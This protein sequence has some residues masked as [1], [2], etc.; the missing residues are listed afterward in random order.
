[1]AITLHE[2]FFISSRLLPAIRVGGATVSIEYAA[3]PPRGGVRYRYHID[4]PD[5][6]THSSEDLRS[7]VKEGSLKS[8]MEALL[9]FLAACGES[10]APSATYPG[11][12]ADLFP[13]TVGEWAYQH[14][15]EIEALSLW[16]EEARDCCI[17]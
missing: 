16:I 9:S 11:E 1:M 8:G 5:G 17:E 12:N 3:I 15:D 6:T 13:D 7:G 10:R 4:F 2:P 14:K